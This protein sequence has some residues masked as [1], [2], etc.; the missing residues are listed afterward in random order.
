MTV[1][2][3]ILNAHAAK[4]LDEELLELSLLQDGKVISTGTGK[5]SVSLDGRLQIAV[6]A[7]Y[8]PFLFNPASIGVIIPDK[9]LFGI[10]AKTRD[11]LIFK[12]ERAYAKHISNAINKPAQAIFEAGR[13]TFISNVTP[14]P[15]S[16]LDAFIIPF[17][18]DFP[19]R[20]CAD[21]E[22]NPVFGDIVSGFWFTIE[23]AET[24][25]GL[26]KDSDSWVHLKV[27]SKAAGINSMEK[28]AVAFLNALRFRAGKYLECLAYSHATGK[29]EE[30]VLLS[31]RPESKSKFYE[32]LPDH[33][34]EATEK[35]LARAMDFF[36][37]EKSSPVFTA[38]N[39]CW[40]SRKVTFGARNLLVCSVVEGLA[41]YILTDAKE[42]CGRLRD[43][44]I[45]LLRKESNARE[46]LYFEKVEKCINGVEFF[47]DKESIRK[48]G[49]L[50]KITITDAEL[51]AWGHLR[52]R[53]A[54]GN[55]SFD[56]QS[57]AMMQSEIDRANC[58]ANIVNKFILALV[59]YEG[60]FCDYSARGHPSSKFPV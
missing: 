26:R 37:E 59:G 58:V 41:D 11:N 49:E 16:S 25:I 3:H 27:T 53:L 32:P 52:N 15:Q 45:D 6:N 4:T 43:L 18:C 28:Y 21:G 22:T 39:V 30:I 44:A 36:L 17:D 42:Q 46:S 33:E 60:V 20:R 51:S 57:Q 8:I 31:H 7:E 13:V 55:F 14:Q 54:H 10:S 48:A 19:N 56:F 50:L 47:K 12:A 38:L 29:G 9:E 23:T 2:E 40:E 5:L 35:L 1:K 34:L 24:V